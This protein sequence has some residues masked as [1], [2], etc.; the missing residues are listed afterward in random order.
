M[1]MKI[2]YKK[3]DQYSQSLH[4]VM[5]GHQS[6]LYYY[7][8]NRDNACIWD[9]DVSN[10]IILNSSCAQPLLEALMKCHNLTSLTVLDNESGVGSTNIIE[11]ILKRLKD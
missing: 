11:E 7:R 5:E 1:F 9:R 6:Y 4:N 10:C 3:F 8:E 2:S